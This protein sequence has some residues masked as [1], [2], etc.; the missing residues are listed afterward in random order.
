[1]S[2][3]TALKNLWADR[4]D[5]PSRPALPDTTTRFSAAEAN[6]LKASMYLAIDDLTTLNSEK[7]PVAQTG[8]G[9]PGPGTAGEQDQFYINTDNNTLWRCSDPT[10][11]SEVWVQT[12]G[13]GANALDDLADVDLTTT[14]PNPSELLYFNG[15]SWVPYGLTIGTVTQITSN[16]TAVTLNEEAGIITMFD[17]V[18]PITSETFTLNNSLIQPNSSI[19]LAVEGSTAAD[20]APS[21]SYNNKASGSVDI[22]VTNHDGTNPSEVLK[23]HFRIIGVAPGGGGGQQ[24]TRTIRHIVDANEEILNNEYWCILKGTTT[25]ASCLLPANPAT[26]QEHEISVADI[27]NGA[28]VDGNGRNIRVQPNVETA[29]LSFVANYESVTVRY[30]NVDNVWYVG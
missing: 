1:M 16:S 27:A 22:K 25:S 18:A 21:V 3:L 5:D 8:S 4:I 7:A 26:G 9:V 19:Q 24:V 12:G 15:S 10:P 28:T 29:V 30:D 17:A 14:P 11:S 23:V 6:A 2:T 20:V 13:G